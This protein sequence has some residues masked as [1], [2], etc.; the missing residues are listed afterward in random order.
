MS[1]IH[2][3]RWIRRSKARRLACFATILGCCWLP[4]TWARDDAAVLP[5]TLRNETLIP[6]SFLLS[7]Y[8][9]SFV[10]ENASQLEMFTLISQTPMES[11]DRNAP[12]VTRD[13]LSNKSHMIDHIERNINRCPKTLKTIKARF[14]F[15]FMLP[16]CTAR[17]NCTARRCPGPGS[18][19]IPHVDA[20]YSGA[21]PHLPGNPPYP[22]K[23]PR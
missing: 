23:T 20:A 8:A 6:F 17:K 2:T 10:G 3:M 12:C 19:P 11:A 21:R 16:A 4:F 22:L 1:A 15:R 9:E 18:Y 13:S 7:S 14:G 5:T